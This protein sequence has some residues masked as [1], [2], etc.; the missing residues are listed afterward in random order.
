ML[1]VDPRQKSRLAERIANL[2]DRIAEAK[3]YGW[4]GEVQGLQVSLEAGQAKMA[5]LLRAE[6]NRP[7]GGLTDLGMPVLVTQS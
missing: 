7:A 4:G 3:A 2:K 5:S 1:R 6:R